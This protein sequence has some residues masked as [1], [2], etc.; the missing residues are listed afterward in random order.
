MRIDYQM[1]RVG[2]VDCDEEGLWYMVPKAGPPWS[3]AIDIAAPRQKIEQSSERASPGRR[4]IHESRV[5]F[6][7]STV[8]HS[9]PQWPPAVCM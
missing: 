2:L 3:M 6:I 9:G 8:A 1:M 7:H 5:P 4:D